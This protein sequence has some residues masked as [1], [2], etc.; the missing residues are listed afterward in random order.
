[1]RDQPSVADELTL[2]ASQVRGDSDLPTIRA[3]HRARL[4]LT[5]L[6]P[7]P[8]VDADRSF[9]VTLRQ[10]DEVVRAFPASVAGDGRSLSLV[11]EEGGLQEGPYELIARVRPGAGAP[12]EIAAYAFRVIPP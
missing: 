11:L 8:V 10:G 3:R 5:L 2:G 12:A 9:D 6:V 4:H 1:N 7:E